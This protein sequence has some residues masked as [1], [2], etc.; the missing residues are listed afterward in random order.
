VYL[1]PSQ[2]SRSGLP[3]DWRGRVGLVCVREAD[4]TYDWAAPMAPLWAQMRAW[5]LAA[6][7]RRNHSDGAVVVPDLHCRGLA[8]SRVASGV[9]AGRR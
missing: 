9:R 6:P 4:M 1:R 7:D 3:L 8:R 5:F 2:Q